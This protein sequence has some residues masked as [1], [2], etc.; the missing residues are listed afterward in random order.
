MLVISVLVCLDCYSTIPS[1][2][3]LI[4]YRIYFS[5]FRRLESEI[6]VP[7]WSGSGEDPLPS[8]PSAIR[9]GLQPFVFRSIIIRYI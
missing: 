6:R 4:N 1:P 3:G 7:A 9:R 5:Q 2:G 8:W